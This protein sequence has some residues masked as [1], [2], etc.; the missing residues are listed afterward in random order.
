MPRSAA[1]SRKT[2]MGWCWT[3]G[4]AAVIAMLTNSGFNEIT[5]VILA[6]SGSISFSVL[7][8]DFGFLKAPYAVGTPIRSFFIIGFLCAGMGL[9]AFNAWPAGSVQFDSR[10]EM[11]IPTMGDYVRL[12]YYFR[13]RGSRTIQRVQSWGAIMFLDPNANSPERVDSIWRDSI[14]KFYKEHPNNGQTSAP[15]IPSGAPPLAIRS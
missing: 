14:R 9:L 1:E 12:N 3:F 6:V 5:L 11:G 8:R 2:R 7:A 10:R 15:M 4:I 13:N